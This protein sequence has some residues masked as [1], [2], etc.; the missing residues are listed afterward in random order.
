MRAANQPPPKWA[1]FLL[2]CL[3][4]HRD[5]EAVAGDLRE[6]YME[7][8]LPSL[9]RSRA[10][11]WYLHQLPGFARRCVL[12]E[13]TMERALFCS[14]LF[15]SLCG[16]W[17]AAMESLLRHPGYPLR[18]G[19]EL[20]IVAICIAAILVRVLH[21]GIR[22]ERW[23]WPAGV[24]LIAVGGA[25]FYR[26]AHATHFE[27]FV[28]LISVAFALQGILMVLLLGRADFRWGKPE[29]PNDTGD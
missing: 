4:S 26:N 7:S 18:I 16:C 19:M 8:V 12:E 15:T 25:S 2:E 29:G 24:A 20:S 9:G 28:A 11:I 1:E 27:G 5:R 22:G 21:A 10:N 14:S 23:L 17:L 6:E 13:G 3:L